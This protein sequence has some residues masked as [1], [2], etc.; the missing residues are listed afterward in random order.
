MIESEL[1]PVRKCSYRTA[2]PIFYKIFMD[3]SKAVEQILNWDEI[4]FCTDLGVT[5]PYKGREVLK[6]H[7]EISKILLDDGV[8]QTYIGLDLSRDEVRR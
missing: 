1:K 6:L 8:G 2:S 4:P 7:D 5:T 3:A